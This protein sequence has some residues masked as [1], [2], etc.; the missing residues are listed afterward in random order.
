[1]KKN[2][3]IKKMNKFKRKAKAAEDYLTLLEAEMSSTALDLDKKRD[4]NSYVS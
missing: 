3:R 1:M 4:H 2:T